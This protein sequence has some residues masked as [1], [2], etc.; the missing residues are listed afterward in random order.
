MKTNTDEEGTQMGAEVQ[1]GQNHKP[2][3]GAARTQIQT[4]TIP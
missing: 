3:T 4:G 1:T 2:P